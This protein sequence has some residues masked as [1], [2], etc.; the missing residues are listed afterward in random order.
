MR[1]R[2][3]ELA[4]LAALV[5]MILAGCERDIPVAATSTI[6]VSG[7]RIE[8]TITDGLRR[9]LVGVPIRLFYDPTFVGTDSIPTMSYLLQ[10]V[11]EFV[12]V[13]VYTS[14]GQ[15]VRSLFAQTVTDTAIVIIWDQ[16]SDAG[17]PV[18]SGL[19]SVQYRVGSEIRKSY[20]VIVD[21]N[22]T[23]TTDSAGFYSVN[24]TNLPVGAVVQYYN[25]LTFL[26]WYRL[27][28]SVFLQIDAPTLNRIYHVALEKNIVTEFSLIVE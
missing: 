13:L 21:G 11:N 4:M 18:A 16:R 25:G 10:A 6:P 27:E 12:R 9:P 8:G 14:S 28:P 22:I 19:Y 15:F 17:V 23:A 2:F 24:E 3:L 7:Y 20:D 5:T 26:G 1:N